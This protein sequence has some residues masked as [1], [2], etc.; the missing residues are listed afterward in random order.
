MTDSRDWQEPDNDLERLVRAAGHYVQASS[1]LRPRVIESARAECGQ[2]RLRRRL[3]QVA[4][5]L[6][7]VGLL[8][9][10]TRQFR[11]STHTSRDAW[12]MGA[13]PH[14]GSV[15]QSSGRPADALGWETVDAFTEV[16]RRQAEA[17]R[18]EQ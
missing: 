2:R 18:P 4:I 16:R 5:V 10:S 17:I 13:F 15:W 8:A 11:N 12:L 9:A 3:L 14:G 1:D 7:C 6:I